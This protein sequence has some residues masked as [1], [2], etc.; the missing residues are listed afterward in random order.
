[1]SSSNEIAALI[2]RAAVAHSV[3]EAVHPEDHIFNFIIGHR[4]FPNDKSRVDY[5]FDDGKQSS[6][7]LLKLVNEFLPRIERARLLEFASGYGCVTRH[8]ARRSDR[9]DLVSC[10]IHEAAIEF[11]RDRID[12]KAVLSASHPERLQADG[13]YDFTF[14]L[15]FFSHMP[16][17]TWSRWL[18]KLCDTVRPGGIVAFT[19]QGRHS[20]RFLGCTEIPELG[21]WF[22]PESEQHDLPVEEYGQTIIVPELVR[23]MIHSIAGV[24]LLD[25]REAHWWDHQDLFVIRRTL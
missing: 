18:V 24:E 13:G 23:K 1:M 16:V 10:D 19:T 4:G 11:L 21:F 14:A 2:K 17:T 3:E 5:Y 15:S 20:M 6:D 7:K 12:V 25:A 9:I 22:R 8:L